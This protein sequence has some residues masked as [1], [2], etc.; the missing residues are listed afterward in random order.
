MGSF[1]YRFT[2]FS[3]SDAFACVI[4]VLMSFAKETEDGF[5]IQIEQLPLND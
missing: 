2:T 4:T 5:K 3:T 1:L